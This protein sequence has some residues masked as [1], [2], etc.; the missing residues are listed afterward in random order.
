MSEVRPL[1]EFWYPVVRI[2]LV[3]KSLLAATAPE[4]FAGLSV[5]VRRELAWAGAFVRRYLLALARALVLPPVRQKTQK[6]APA[7]PAS[8]PDT[9][10]RRRLARPFCLA[11]PPAPQRAP[12]TPRG[13][14]ASPHVEWALALHRTEL[15]LAALRR[16][17]PLAQR[18]ARRMARGHPPLLRASAVRWHVL[19]ALPP[20]LDTLL[21]RLDCL[22]RPDHWSGIEPDLGPDTG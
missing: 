10:A 2:L 12:G 20:A 19:R 4:V 18:L 7:A 1:P 16:T 11:E 15:L 17:L 9:P 13:E 14:P 5:R 3:L 6:G 22:A 21:T 8:L